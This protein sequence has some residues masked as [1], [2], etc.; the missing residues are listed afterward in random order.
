MNRIFCRK[1]EMSSLLTPIVKTN[2][3]LLKMVL[4]P[5]CL[6]SFTE[7][8]SINLTRRPVAQS[9]MKIHFIVKL[10]VPA[11][12]AMHPLGSFIAFR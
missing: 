12:V 3:R 9:L 7:S 10:K 11:E 6:S 4:T 8:L 5:V 2:F 1:H